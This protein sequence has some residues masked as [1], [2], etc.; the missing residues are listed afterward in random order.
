M[1]TKKTDYPF[2]L[3]AHVGHALPPAKKDGNIYVD[4]RVRG[5]WDGILVFNKQSECIG[6]YC[7]RRI[8]KWPLPF[9]PAEIEAVRP[10]CFVNRLMASFPSGAI[11]AF[12]YVCLILL[13]LLIFAD[14]FVG[15][16]GP[17]LAILVGVVGQ[18][19]VLKNMRAYCLTNLI[20]V[21]AILALQGIALVTMV[22]ALRA[23]G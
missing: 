22:K 2:V 5:K 11:L 1:T 6:A 12:P 4:V 9:T 3:P 17:A 23:G 16:C 21:T 13:P 15:F 18:T 19:I 10:A 14:R 8:D 7:G 20:L